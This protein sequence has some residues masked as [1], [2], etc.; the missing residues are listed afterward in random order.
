MA[1]RRSDWAIADVRIPFGMASGTCLYSLA[2]PFFSSTF[3]IH[4]SAIAKH[5][6]TLWPRDVNDLVRVSVYL[7]FFRFSD[8]NH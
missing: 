4:Q 6:I 2:T 5:D 8:I 1:F 7:T 3:L